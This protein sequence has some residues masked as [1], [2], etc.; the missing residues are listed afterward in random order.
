MIQDGFL[1][2]VRRAEFKLQM[3]EISAYVKGKE[4]NSVGRAGP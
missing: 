2:E 3:Q 4:E 1:E